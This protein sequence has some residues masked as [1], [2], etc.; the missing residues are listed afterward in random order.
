MAGTVGGIL[1][2]ST[3]PAEFIMQHY[4]GEDHINVGTGQDLSIGELAGMVRLAVH[5]DAEVVFDTSKPDGSPRELLDVTR[6]HGLGWTHRISLREGV[7]STY[8]WF[9]EHQ[10]SLRMKGQVATR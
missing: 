9:L 4:E 7:E 3:R 6:P 5:P 10:A 1:A 2:N 8:Q